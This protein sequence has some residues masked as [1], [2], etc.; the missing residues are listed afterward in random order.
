MKEKR[1]E[2][3]MAGRERRLASESVLQPPELVH[4]T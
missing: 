2:I 1:N 3:R 4:V